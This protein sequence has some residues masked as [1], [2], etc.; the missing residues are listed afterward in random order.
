MTTTNILLA[1]VLLAQVVILIAI[2]RLLTL[3]INKSSSLQRPVQKIEAQA[4]PIEKI[5]ERIFTTDELINYWCQYCE[6][7]KEK[8]KA[9]RY[10]LSIVESKMDVVLPIGK[11]TASREH[12]LKLIFRQN[13]MTAG[14]MAIQEFPIS[15]GQFT[16]LENYFFANF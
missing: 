8:Q 12:Q 3:S 13:Y 16:Q 9:I 1:L 10:T 15:S 2:R 11:L 5:P 14:G 7:N 4:K 6:A